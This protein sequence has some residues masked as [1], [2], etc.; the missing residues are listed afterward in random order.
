MKNISSLRHTAWDCKYH[1]VWVPK[2]RKTILY[3]H[4]RRHLGD[5]F[6]DLALQKESEILEGH[7]LG[8]HVHIMVSIPPKYAISQVVGYIKRK[9]TIQN[10][11]RYM[12][13]TQSHR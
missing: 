10:A 13:T 9:S 6:K 4:L 11:R 7:L 8:D 12:W 1:I 5:I 3:G 2:Y